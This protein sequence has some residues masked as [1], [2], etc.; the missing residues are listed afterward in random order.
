MPA[1]KGRRRRFDPVSGHHFSKTYKPLKSDYVPLRS[2]R[3]AESVSNRVSF[4]FNLPMNVKDEW[5]Q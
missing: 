3:V 1:L 4:V 5:N 2:N